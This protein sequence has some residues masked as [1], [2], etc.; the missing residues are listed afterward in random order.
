MRD[1][2][3]A[4][5]SGEQ[6]RGGSVHQRIRHHVSPIFNEAR[7]LESAGSAASVGALGVL[8]R[9]CSG[10]GSGVWFGPRSRL[11]RMKP[12]KLYNS[13]MVIPPRGRAAR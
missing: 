13:G 1:V 5:G 6:H 11:G 3:V 7:P 9:A 4:S 12:I 10:H 2:L 8:G